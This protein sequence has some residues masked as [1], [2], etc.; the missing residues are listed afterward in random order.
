MTTHV[1]TDEQKKAVAELLGLE[2]E[3]V[4]SSIELEDEES[5]EDEDEEVD[6]DEEEDEDESDDEVE[7]SDEDD[8]EDDSEDEEE[9]SDDEDSD[10]EESSL[11]VRVQEATD[12]WYSKHRETISLADFLKTKGF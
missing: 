2:L 4:P 8:E 6:E 3:A 12:E 10:A 7:D 9:D 1:L 5:N 11:A